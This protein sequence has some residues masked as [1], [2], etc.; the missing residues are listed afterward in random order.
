MVARGET[1]ESI[2][3]N[4]ITETANGNT[5]IDEGAELGFGT[6]FVAEDEAGDTRP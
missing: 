1:D 6:L 4:R 5:A 3:R 2:Y